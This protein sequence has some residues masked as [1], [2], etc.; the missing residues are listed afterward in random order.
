M[1]GM[2]AICKHAE[3]DARLSCYAMPHETPPQSRLAGGKISS[4]DI[5]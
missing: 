4:S 1:F 2:L 3:G 5:I